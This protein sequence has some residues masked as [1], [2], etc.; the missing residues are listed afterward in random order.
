M[1]HKNEFDVCTIF[2]SKFKSVISQEPIEQQIIPVKNNNNDKITNDQ[3]YEYC[4]PFI[5]FNNNLTQFL[6]HS[7][8]IIFITALVTFTVFVSYLLPYKNQTTQTLI[9]GS[10]LGGARASGIACAESASASANV[11]ACESRKCTHTASSTADGGG[12]KTDGGGGGGG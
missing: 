7:Y 3:N 9:R 6:S 8:H 11:C 12:M 10:A 1:F 4:C 2:Y 5:A